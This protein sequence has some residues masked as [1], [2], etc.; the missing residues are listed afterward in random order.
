MK[1]KILFLFFAVFALSFSSNAQV[2]LIGVGA[3]GCWDNTGCDVDLV[4]NGGGIWTLNGYTMPGGEFK[5]RLNHDWNAPNGGAWGN[6]TFPI[7]TGDFTPGSANIV[8][9]AGTYDITFNQNTG[10]YSFSGGAPIPVVKLVGSAVPN[11][12][13]VSFTTLDGQIYTANNVTL[14]SGDAQFDIDGALLGST[15]FP[16]GTLVDNSLFIPVTAG[17]YS[18]IT[19]DIGLNTYTFVAAPVFHTIA[20]VGSGAGGWPNDPQVDANVLTT[21]DGDNY[22]GTV[23]LTAGEI[24]FRQDN[25]WTTSWGGV[26]FPTGPDVAH[27]GDNIIV[28]APGT[29]DVTFNR[30]SGAYTFS[31]PT[32]AIV[33]SGAGGWPSDPQV[34]ANVLTTT[35]GAIYTLLGVTLTDGEAKFRQ[36]NDWTVNWGAASFPVGIGTQGGANIPTTAGTYDVTFNRLTGGFSFDVLATAS[37]KNSN[38]RVYP[39]PTQ[40]IWNFASEKAAIQTISIVDVIGKTIMTISP[41]NSAATID[42]SSL[43]AG[44]YFAKIA[45]A[46]ATETVKLVKN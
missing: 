15:E 24:K 23:T 4:D 26:T 19:V 40:N 31:F 43:K 28:T 38:F 39:N 37:F 21:T 6:S 3:T 10:E 2:S 1:R 11:V 20:L 44:I 34:D 46:T 22:T 36:N 25:S 13:G 17:E 32:I 16:S 41:K 45:T 7:G 12:N 35:D 30:T 5:F 42:A 9:I 27:P 14:N 29:Y 8:A 33:G 18:S